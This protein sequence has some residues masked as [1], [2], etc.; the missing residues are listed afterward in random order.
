MTVKEEEKNKK[1]KRHIENNKIVNVNQV[2][3][4]N[5]ERSKHRSQKQK[6]TG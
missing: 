6:L 1:E 2:T 3:P 4:V 5:C